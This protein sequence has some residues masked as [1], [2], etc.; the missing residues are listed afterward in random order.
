MQKDYNSLPMIMTEAEI[1][2]AIDAIICE[3]RQS[4]APPA[5]EVA[6]A[7]VAM[8]V[9]QSSCFRPFARAVAAK[10]E[11]WVVSAWSPTS[12]PL[13]DAISML[14][15]NTNSGCVG[16]QLLEQSRSSTNPEIRRIAEEA[17]AEMDG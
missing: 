8:V 2:Q 12:V 3:A 4:P 15:V 10:V 17:L 9:R 1:A 6:Q 11:G 7:L 13:V 14:I 5:L 16:R